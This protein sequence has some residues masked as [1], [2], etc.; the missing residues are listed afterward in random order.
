MFLKITSKVQGGWFDIAHRL[1]SFLYY[2]KK[3]RV[4][5]K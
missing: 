1:K 4:L 3:F 2:T 5:T